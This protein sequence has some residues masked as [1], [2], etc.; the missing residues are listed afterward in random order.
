M[1][2]VEL[3]FGK[4]FRFISSWNVSLIWL[5]FMALASLQICWQILWLKWVNGMT[6]NEKCSMTLNYKS[7]NLHI[8]S[9]CSTTNDVMAVMAAEMP[10]LF[11]VM[12][13]YCMR[14]VSV[15]EAKS[16]I[17]IMRQGFQFLCDGCQTKQNMWKFKVPSLNSKSHHTWVIS[18]I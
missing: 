5:F 4:N 1:L 10:H 3:D 12:Q 8:S 9:M 13:Q 14:C 6:Q 18:I 11:H 17:C 7:R 15:E 2:K 16:K